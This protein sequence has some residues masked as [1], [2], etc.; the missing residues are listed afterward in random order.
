MRSRE[1]ADARNAAFFNRRGGSEAGKSRFPERCVRDG[2]G[3]WSD[4]SRNR[5]IA[6]KKFSLVS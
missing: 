1:I 2:L 3:S 6:I 4:H 5:P